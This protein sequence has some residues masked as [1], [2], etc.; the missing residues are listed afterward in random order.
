[1]NMLLFAVF[2]KLTLQIIFDSWWAS[3]NVG[4]MHAIAWNNSRPAP[5]WQFYLHCGIDTTGCPGVICIVCHQVLP[6]PSD[7]RTSL[8]GKHLLTKVHITKLKDLT[9]SGVTELTSSTVD[10]TAL[11]ILKWQGSRGYYNC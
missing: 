3:M 11:A 2:C 7:H 10:E 9:E 6:H 5:L 4:S 8:I 1:M